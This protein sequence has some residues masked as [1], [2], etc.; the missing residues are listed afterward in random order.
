MFNRVTLARSLDKRGN[1]TRSTVPGYLLPLLSARLGAKWAF[2]G[3]GGW[4]LSL[5]ALDS[6]RRCEESV[7]SPPTGIHGM[8]GRAHMYL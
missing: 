7:V 5:A 3:R 4:F 2:G 1:C 8:G 6:M